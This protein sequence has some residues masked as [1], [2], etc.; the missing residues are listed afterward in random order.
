[1]SVGAKTVLITGASGGVG[2]QTVT[3]LVE[4]GWRVFA[5]VRSRSTAAALD[6]ANVVPVDLDITDE[7]SIAAARDRVSVEVGEAGLFALVNNAGLSV[8]GP[9]ELVPAHRLRQQFEVNVI[10]Q[11]AVAQA[12]LPLLRQAG[13][14]VINIGGAAGSVALPLMGALGASKAALDSASDALRMELRL[15]GVAVSYIEPGALT[16]E[17]FVKS[18]EVVKREGFAGGAREFALYQPAILRMEEAMAKQKPTPVVQAAET[19]VAALTARK[20]KARYRVGREARYVLPLL[21]LVPVGLR[22]RMILSSLGLNAA[23]GELKRA[24]GTGA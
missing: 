15:Q 22:D 17:L 9:L 12:F 21:R 6:G 19:I 20:P 3:L 11:L 2:R 8:D 14:R 7:D 24:A 10:G 1:M 5:G 23:S 4:R 13:G 18:A 16:T